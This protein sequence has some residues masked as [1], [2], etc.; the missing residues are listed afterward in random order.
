MLGARVGSWGL[1]FLPGD[2]YSFAIF[3]FE[4]GFI[5]IGNFP[6]VPGLFAE[7]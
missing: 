2:F 4:H 1:V 3:L 6:R 5:A 7:F